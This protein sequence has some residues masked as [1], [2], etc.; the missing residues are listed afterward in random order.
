MTIVSFGLCAHVWSWYLGSGRLKGPC[1]YMQVAND[2]GITVS[3]LDRS[4]VSSDAI[5]QV[6]WVRRG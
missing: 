1:I 6:A 2:A 3:S 4:C 5:M